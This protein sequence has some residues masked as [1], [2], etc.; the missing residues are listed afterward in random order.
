MEHV[1]TVFPE[2]PV[3]QTQYIKR[4]GG[5]TLFHGARVAR[6]LKIE[7]NLFVTL[8]FWETSLTIFEMADAF[9][10]IREK[11]GHWVQRPPQRHSAFDA[12]PT[13]LWVLENPPDRD[14]FHAHWLVYVPP[15]RQADFTEMLDKW[16]RSAAAKI[17]NPTPFHVEPVSA[18]LGITAYMLKGQFPTVASDHGVTPDYQGWIPGRKRS[19]SSKN[20]GPTEH[21]RLWKAGKHPRPRQ[22]I[23]GRFNNHQRQIM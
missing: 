9:A 8:K 11:F 23:K 22:Y 12:P 4:K 3:P 15:E 16:M 6:T 5:R 18:L 19:G 17:Y 10:R 14:Q 20:L 1:S 13:F 21:E 7:P 2:R